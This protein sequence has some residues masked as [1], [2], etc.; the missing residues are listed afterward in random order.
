MRSGWTL[1]SEECGTVWEIVDF[2]DL[3]MSEVRV[4]MKQICE[5][6]EIFEKKW[7]NGQFSKVRVKMN[8]NWQKM[9]DEWQKMEKFEEFRP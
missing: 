6:M 9:V 1:G 4:K 8:Q 5:K 7:K 2:G 3:G